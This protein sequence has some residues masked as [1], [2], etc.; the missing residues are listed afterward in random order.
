MRTRWILALGAAAVVAGCATSSEIENVA[1][2][3]QQKAQLYQ[4]HGDY[5]A[6]ASEQRAA[7]K[8]FAKAQRRAYDEAYNRAYWW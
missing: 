2:E 8:Q 4:A 6:A 1:Y 7:D 3:H 5:S